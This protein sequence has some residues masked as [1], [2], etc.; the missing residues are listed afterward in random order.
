[1]FELNGAETG[2]GFFEIRFDKKTPWYAR[3]A[4]TLGPIRGRLVA[5]GIL[6]LAL[7]CVM[8]R[9]PGQWILDHGYVVES[10]QAYKAQRLVSWIFLSITLALYASVFWFRQE[11]LVL[12]FDRAKLELNIEHTPLGARNPVFEGTCPFAD[13]SGIEVLAPTT[14]TEFGAVK[15]TLKPAALER[16]GP[17]VPDL[18]FQ[19]LSHEQRAIYPKNLSRITG[20]EPTG[21]WTDSDDDLATSQEPLNV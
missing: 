16:L 19:V 11:K 8:T 18:S 21:D 7:I 3:F 6:V 1:M 14:E 13:L 5:M 10:V 20:L 17:S 9:Q 4:V 12:R 15:L 2:R